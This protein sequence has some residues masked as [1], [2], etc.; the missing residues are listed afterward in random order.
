MK[1]RIV[2]EVFVE[3]GTGDEPGWE[4]LSSI[5]HV[6]E[7]DSFTDALPQFNKYLNDQWAQV[8]NMSHVIDEKPPNT[9]GKGG[10]P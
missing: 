3:D 7:A 5:G 8:A 2:T 6:A 4:K 1:Y 10:G 9:D